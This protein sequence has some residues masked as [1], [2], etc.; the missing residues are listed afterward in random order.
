[1]FYLTPKAMT[2]SK[3]PGPIPLMYTAKHLIAL[4][5]LMALSD[6][7]QQNHITYNLCQMFL[8]F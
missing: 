3:L 6:L 8:H 1:M 7:I 2:S 4:T 5:T